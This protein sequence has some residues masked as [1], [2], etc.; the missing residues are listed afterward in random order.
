MRPEDER[1]ARLSMEDGAY[2][3]AAWASG[4]D[5]W[6][7]AQSFGFTTPTPVRNAI[8]RFEQQWCD[9]TYDPMLARM[10][11][12]KAYAVRVRRGLRLFRGFRDP[13]G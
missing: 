7:I 12:R 4:E 10:S 1:G 13:P 2:A 11:V 8:R 9:L 5:Q 6:S 3:A